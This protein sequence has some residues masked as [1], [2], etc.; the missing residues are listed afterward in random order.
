[1]AR[2]SSWRSTCGDGALALFGEGA[3]RTRS[4]QPPV[5][6]T[7]ELP[8][9]SYRRD[10]ACISDKTEVRKTMA[11]RESLALCGRYPFEIE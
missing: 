2:L 8:S 6:R 10:R 1:M 7:G 5:R 4:G 3:A 9:F 11:L